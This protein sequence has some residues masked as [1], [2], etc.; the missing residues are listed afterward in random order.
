MPRPRESGDEIFNPLLTDSSDKS[1]FVLLFEYVATLDV[2]PYLCIEEALRFRREVCGGEEKIMKY[3]QDIANQAGRKTVEIL[4]TDIMENETKTLTKCAMV[5]VRLPLEVGHGPG[6]ILEKD[7]YLVAVWMTAMLV[8]ESDIYLPVYFHARKFWTRLSGQVYLDLG[9]FE[10][11]AR[12]LK[13]LCER[14]KMGQYQKEKP[15]L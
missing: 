11:G 4:G 2:C 8:K 12:A 15:R 9:D 1:P 13:V 6:Q 3:C 10:K 7:M 14:A 5:N